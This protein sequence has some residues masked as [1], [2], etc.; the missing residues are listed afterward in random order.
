LPPSERDR[1]SLK[2]RLRQNTLPKVQF[3]A[4]RLPTGFF[5]HS[6]KGKPYMPV[7]SVFAATFM[8][9]SGNVIWQSVLI[10][11]LPQYSAT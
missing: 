2:R 11:S 8:M 1:L 3:A 9:A 4:Y 6:E 7:K 10:T 5:T